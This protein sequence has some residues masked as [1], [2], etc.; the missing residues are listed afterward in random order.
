MCPLMYTHQCL[1]T[2]YFEKHWLGK[3]FFSE[4]NDFANP[5]A[6]LCRDVSSSY[7]FIV[8]KLVI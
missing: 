1:W 4:V 3:R 7:G 6:Y 2:A 8:Q 5:N